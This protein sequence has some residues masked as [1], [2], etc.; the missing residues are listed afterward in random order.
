MPLVSGAFGLSRRSLPG[1]V[2]VIQ[3]VEQLHRTR[4]PHLPLRTVFVERLI[5]TLLAAASQSV[6]AEFPEIA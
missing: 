1:E 4:A 3:D 6:A 2:H 5:D